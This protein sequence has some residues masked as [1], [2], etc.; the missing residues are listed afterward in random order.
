MDQPEAVQSC[1]SLNPA[2][3]LAFWSTRRFPA[4]EVGPYLA[5]HCAGAIATSSVTRLAFGPLGNLGATLPMVPLG[6]A[7]GVEWLLS[8][9][10]MLVI[11]AVATDERVAGESGAL[12]VGAT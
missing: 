1:L 3:T 2:V 11:M 4:S 8:L 5:A 10:L 6:V 9:M 7:L 12:A